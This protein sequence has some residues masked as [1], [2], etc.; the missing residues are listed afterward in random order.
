M[1]RK[2]CT[3]LLSFARTLHDQERVNFINK[4]SSILYSI[5]GPGLQTLGVALIFNSDFW[6]QVKFSYF[7]PCVQSAQFNVLVLRLLILRHD[8]NWL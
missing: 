7:W 5:C 3:S 2:L 6:A 1:N 8:L 4:I